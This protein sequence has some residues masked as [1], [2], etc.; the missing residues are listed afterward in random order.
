MSDPYAAAIEALRRKRDEIVS[1]IAM[2]EQMTGGPALAAE[3]TL[4]TEAPRP[5]AERR[6]KANRP[7][8]AKRGRPKPDI[9]MEALRKSFEQGDGPAL[10]EARFG[11]SNSYI[12]SQARKNGWQ[13][14]KLG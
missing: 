11:C 10:M 5:R 6:P 3:A 9:D 13:R 8:G 14:P 4:A 12:Y 7:A 1:V 2:L